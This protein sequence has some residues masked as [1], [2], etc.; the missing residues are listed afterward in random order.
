MT[1]IEFDHVVYG[2]TDSCIKEFQKALIDAGHKI[3]SGPTGKYGDETKKACAAFQRDQGW[4][5]LPGPKT[6][7][8]LKLKDGGHKGK[9]VSSPVPGATVSLAYGV[10]DSR[11]Q[12]GYHTGR[13]YAAAEG[14][15]VIAVRAGSIAKSVGG[16][17][18]YGNYLV[19]RAD[20]GR[21]YWHCHLS[22]RS[23][24]KGDK[25]KAG[26]KLGEVGSTG[27]AYGPHLHFEDRPEGGPYGDD[28]DPRW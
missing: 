21:D 6:F 9:G 17:E 2:S 16:D 10:R 18:S 1:A 24:G 11:Y 12:A 22:H 3:P 13:D 8:A 14:A 15:K 28:R 19:L 26:Q 5:G 7:A 25:V 4:D 23:V 20:N 27:K